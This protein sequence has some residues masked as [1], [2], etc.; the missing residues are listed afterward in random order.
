MP[1]SIVKSYNQNSRQL[2]SVK[3]TSEK[4]K[5]LIQ[6]A[7]EKDKGNITILGTGDKSTKRNFKQNLF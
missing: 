3:Q 1:S 2:A 7:N 5:S 6:A 4:M